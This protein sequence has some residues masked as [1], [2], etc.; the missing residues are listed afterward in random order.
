LDVNSS[1]CIGRFLRA[2]CIVLVVCSLC[3]NST[4]VLVDRPEYNDRYTEDE[5]KNNYTRLRLAV[6]V[7][8]IVKKARGRQGKACLC[9]QSVLS[10]GEA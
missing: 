8:F 6:T 1:S 3:V 10:V 7:V 9:G 4:L 5:I 2:L